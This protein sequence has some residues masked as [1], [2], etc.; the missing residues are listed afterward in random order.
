MMPITRRDFHALV[1]WIAAWLAWSWALRHWGEMY[2]AYR[3][4][5][6][7]S[8]QI[9]ALLSDGVLG[10]AC[11][12][13]GVLLVRRVQVSNEPMLETPNAT[14]AI[15]A[16]EVASGTLRIVGAVS[17][18]TATQ[19]LATGLQLIVST[20]SKTSGWV[21]LGLGVGLVLV[22]GWMVV[23]PDR[24]HDFIAKGTPDAPT[25]TMPTVATF[26]FGWW[27]LATALVPTVKVVTST[28]FL[29]DYP[30]FRAGFSGQLRLDTRDAASR[31]VLGG[32]LLVVSRWLARRRPAQ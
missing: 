28:A 25:V 4:G 10:L 2:F 15:H 14:Q 8:M 7:G 27:V 9:A 31:V 11:L 30:E 32:V 19:L 6:S 24:F 29:R 12:A 21:A 26:I 18:F 23:S 16:L 22:G 1:T 20:P 13:V 5:N 17:A 3:S